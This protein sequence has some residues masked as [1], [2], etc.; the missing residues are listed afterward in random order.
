MDETPVETADRYHKSMVRCFEKAE[1][2]LLAMKK[3]DPLNTTYQA[4]AVRTREEFISA[5]AAKYNF[6]TATL[7]R[8][9]WKYSMISYGQVH[10][11]MEELWRTHPD[12]SSIQS[13]L[14]MTLKQLIDARLERNANSK[15]KRLEVVQIEIEE[16]VRLAREKFG[17]NSKLSY[18]AC[19]RLIQLSNTA[20]N[21]EIS[22]KFFTNGLDSARNSGD[23]ELE[24]FMLKMLRVTYTNNQKEEK[25]RQIQKN[26]DALKRTPGKE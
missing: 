8:G 5:L 16:L 18:E 20:K 25:A 19:T 9:K 15:T 14:D 2:D 3:N 13:R 22:E 17:L 10:G 12:K 1:A 6:V 24:L 23:K 7:L 21:P 11:A 4:A 26:I